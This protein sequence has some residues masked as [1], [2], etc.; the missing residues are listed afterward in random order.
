MA[1]LMHE[2][3]LTKK[4]KQ[5]DNQFNQAGTSKLW[6]KWLIVNRREHDVQNHMIEVMFLDEFMYK[7]RNRL[8]S[9]VYFL[10]DFDPMEMIQKYCEQ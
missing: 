6:W 4:P 9:S 3:V 10:S 1:Q 5:W 7:V 2:T 8:Y